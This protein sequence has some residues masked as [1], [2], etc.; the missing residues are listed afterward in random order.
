MLAL[1]ALFLLSAC[2]LPVT[3]A[4]HTVAPSGAEFL[5]IQD[6]VDWASGGDTIVVE[7]GTYSETII[8]N[9]KIILEG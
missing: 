4:E 9:K 1:A 5:S 6:A 8:L 2:I 7:S 3:A